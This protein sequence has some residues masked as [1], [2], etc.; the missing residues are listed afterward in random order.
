MYVER[1]PN[2]N[3]P[4]AILI[5][6][7]TRDGKRIVKRTIA[8]IS[9]WPDDQ[10]E[11]LR[12]V[13]KGEPMVPASEAFCVQRSL[14]HGHVEAI[15]ATINNLGF[16]KILGYRRSPE[17]DLVVAMIVEQII[18]SC[19]KLA[20]TRLWHTTTLAEEMSVTDATAEDLYAAL[21]WLLARQEKIEKK[22]ADRHLQE[23][24]TV[25]YDVSSSYYEGH[26]CPLARYGHSKDKKKGKPIIVYGVMTDSE[27]RPIATEVYPGNTGDPTTVADQVDKLRSRFGLSRVLLVGDRGMLTQSRID[28]LRSYP[29]IGWVSALRSK[30]IRTLVEDKHLQMSL[31]DDQNLAEISSPDYPGERLIACMNPLLKAQRRRKRNELLAMTEKCLTGISQQVARRA[32]NP[33]DKAEIGVKV[34]KVV[35]RYKMAKHFKLLIEDGFFSWEHNEESIARESALDGIYVI[36]T[37]EPKEA[38]SAAD[39]VRTYKSLSQVE[40]LFRT[41]KGVDLRVRPIRHRTEDHVRAHILLC[42]LA[43]YIEWHMRKALAP[44]LFEDENLDEDRK[45]RDPVLPASP[46]EAVKSKKINRINSEGYPVHSFETLLAELATRCRNRCSMTSSPSGATFDQLTERTE[47]QQRIME[48]LELRGTQ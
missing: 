17:R 29:G 7:A 10:I 13:L 18:H 38:L 15:L 24:A 48:L 31:F 26:T 30:S 37:S 35:N 22:L 21:D 27:G 12:H 2:R 34:G 4:P 33:L 3:S 23:G 41:L 39:T 45:T 42:T 46:S 14:P 1:V 19:S 8:N 32:K 43:Y 28:T 6:E 9:H 36:R 40:L 44:L 25:L 16:N 11:A 47:L 20:S 5:R